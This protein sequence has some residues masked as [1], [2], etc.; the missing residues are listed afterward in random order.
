MLGKTYGAIEKA[1][2][3]IAQTRWQI[4]VERQPWGRGRS[5]V[6]R[7]I[8]SRVKDAVRFWLDARHLYTKSVS[9]ETFVTAQIVHE[10]WAFARCATSL[11]G[12]LAVSS[13]AKTS[14]LSE[15]FC[16]VRTWRLA[17]QAEVRSLAA[18]GSLI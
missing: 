6:E 17:I 8:C 12:S 9:A 5:S 4:S 13:P 11:R 10:L 7:R 1:S 15:F 14:L 3:S 2:G 16:D 18:L